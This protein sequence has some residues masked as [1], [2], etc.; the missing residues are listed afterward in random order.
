MTHAAQ[1]WGIEQADRQMGWWYFIAEGLSYISGAII[2]AVSRMDH[3]RVGGRDA[4]FMNSFAFRRDCARGSLIFG[5][6]R[7][8]S[9]MFV[10]LRARRGILLGC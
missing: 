1:V 9:F 10:L 6:A 8:R 4:D 2:Y 3:L 5:V 7:I